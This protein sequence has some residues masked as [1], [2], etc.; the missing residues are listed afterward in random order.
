MTPLGAGPKVRHADAA[1]DVADQALSRLQSVRQ[2]FG[3]AEAVL[4]ASMNVASHKYSLRILL[5]LLPCIQLHGIDRDHRLADLYHTAWTFKEGAPGEIHAL[6]QTTD[7]F[8]VAWDGNRIVSF[9]WNS[10]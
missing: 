3:K 4:G 1:C 9:R 8:L 7:G 5:I 10:I 2:L 6:A